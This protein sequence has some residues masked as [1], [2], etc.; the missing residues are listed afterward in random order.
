MIQRIQSVY[1]LL[2]TVILSVCA[3]VSQGYFLTAEGAHYDFKPLGIILEDQTFSTW[4][5][6]ALL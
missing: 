1:L 6:F 4:A 5:L 3:F 2:V